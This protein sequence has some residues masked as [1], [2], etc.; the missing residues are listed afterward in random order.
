MLSGAGDG[1]KLTPLI[2][3][4]SEKGKK[5]VL[6]LRN[7][8]YAKNKNM[9]IYCNPNAWC[10]KYIF[11]EWIFKIFLKYQTALGEKYLLIVD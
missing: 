8:P 10:D 4:K 9:L 3:V 1:T 2:I 11:S 7:L 6:N 5:A